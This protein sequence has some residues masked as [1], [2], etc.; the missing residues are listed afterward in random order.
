MSADKN[1][2]DTAIFAYLLAEDLL[3][4]E[5]VRELTRKSRSDCMPLGQVLVRHRVITIHQ[6]MKVLALQDDDPKARIGELCLR[7]KFCDEE[8]LEAALALQGRSAP[9]GL[10][11]LINEL[12]TSNADMI[13]ALGNYVSGIERREA[14]LEKEVIELRAEVAAL[15]KQLGKDQAA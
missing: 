7:H 8:Q 14:K 10:V 11:V 6:L 9:H 5:D 3:T 2:T 13:A 4:P 1:T 12:G 15:R